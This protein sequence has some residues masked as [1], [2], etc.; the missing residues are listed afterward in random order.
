MTVV[1]RLA[2][3]VA[4]SLFI[5]VPVAAKGP[6]GRLV[7][8]GPGL[9]E[10][11]ELTDTRALVHVYSTDF[12]GPPSAEPSQ[13]LPRYTVSFFVKPPRSEVRMMYVVRYVVAP[14]TA[15]SYVYLPGRGEDGYRLNV[16]TILRDDHDG[17]W[18]EAERG[19]SETIN[20]RLAARSW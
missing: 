7:V 10:S 12:L 19:W 4:T 5:V 9:E 8:S 16:S 18:F 1:T 3:I 17:R 2:W 13:S 11:L 6:T 20:S 15:K 14:N